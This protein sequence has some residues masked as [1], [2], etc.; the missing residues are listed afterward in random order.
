MLASSTAA[1]FTLFSPHRFWICPNH[2]ITFPVPA[3]LLWRWT[4]LHPNIPDFYFNHENAADFRTGGGANLTTA[5]NRRTYIFT[6][7]PESSERNCS[8]S[9]VAI[10]Y[11][12]Q[13]RER[14]INDNETIYSFL[15]LNRSGFD[16]T[17]TNSFTV[18]T[19]PRENNCTNPPGDIQ[20]VCCDNAILGAPNQFKLSST[21]YTFGVSVMNRNVRPLAFANSVA[22]Y[23]YE[24]LQTSIRTP[25]P[26]TLRERDLESDRSLLLL[27]F[28]L[29]TSEQLHYLGLPPKLIFFVFQYS[30]GCKS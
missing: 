1:V 27:R 11:C 14:D 24:Q 2:F 10:Q 21:N 26:F 5:V 22:A 19:I 7:P 25:L 4:G 16:F 3:L 13:A 18:Y 28:I 23:R 15:H 20:R 12:Y 30:P 17:V 8:G 9:V 29:G 6:I